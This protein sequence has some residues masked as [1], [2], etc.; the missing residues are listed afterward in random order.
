MQVLALQGDVADASSL[1]A[2]LAKLSA[3]APPIRGVIHV[4]RHIACGEGTWAAAT[5]PRLFEAQAMA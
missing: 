2:A 3:D 5:A 1:A 4:K